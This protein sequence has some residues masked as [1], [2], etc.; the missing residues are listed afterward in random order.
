MNKLKLMKKAADEITR[1]KALNKSLA[2]KDADRSR[3]RPGAHHGMPVHKEDAQ[4]FSFANAAKG[5]LT[6][7]WSGAK[8]EQE[9]VREATK[10]TATYGDPG[11]LGMIIPGMVVAELVQPLR[12]EL[13]LDKLGV[14]KMTG[15]TYS[16]VEIFG[17]SES[18]SVT[19]LG[20]ETTV[21]PADVV[22]AAG[23]A[24]LAPKTA[25]MASRMSRKLLACG[26][27]AA[28]G[29]IRS[30]LAAIWDREVELRFLEGTGTLGQPR[31]MV[32]RAGNTTTIGDNLDAKLSSLYDMIELLVEDNVS[33]NNLKWFMHERAWLSLQAGQLAV[34]S[35]SASTSVTP[36]IPLSAYMTQNIVDN[37]LSRTLYGYPVITSTNSTV[38]SSAVT[39]VLA[40]WA[41][42]IYADWGAPS[43]EFTIE[44]ETL[45]LAR[46]ALVVMHYDC[47][48]STT[49]PLAIC[50]GTDFD[51]I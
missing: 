4:S 39:V 6:G 8:R 2:K 20:G 7:D 17:L 30:S 25:A 50:T 27:S 24:E 42:T 48:F 28:E 11:N 43:V 10:K 41:E 47:D 19:W 26:G 45:K 46:Q 23:V 14:R 29:I 38:A 31:G 44:G 33:T 40:D 34:S 32:S 3:A 12:S 22:S 36:S 35:A 9:I 15:L 5:M 16:P 18:G 37:K 21:T 49:R 13:Y 51:L 1:L